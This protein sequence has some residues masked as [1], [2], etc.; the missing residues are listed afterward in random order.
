MSEC[1]AFVRS[2][3]AI[4]SAISSV[5][6]CIRSFEADY[7]GAA[8]ALMPEV[9]INRDILITALVYLGA[10]EDYI[11]HG[12]KSRGSYLVTERSVDELIAEGRD[13]E[14]DEEH[15][16]QVQTAL[17]SGGVMKF[18]FSPVRPIPERELW[19][20]NVYNEY[21]KGSVKTPL[22]QK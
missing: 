9:M 16:S 12:G 15:F 6:S 10:I 7:A 1:G 8:P 21:R 18:A 14:T 22:S 4:S 5:R 13:I 3:A 20:E 19:F 11:A 17:Y 2:P